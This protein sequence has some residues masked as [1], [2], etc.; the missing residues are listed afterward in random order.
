MNNNKKSVRYYFHCSLKDHLNVYPH[1]QPLLPS[2]NDRKKALAYG[3]FLFKAA[4]AKQ[5]VNQSPVKDMASRYKTAHWY[6]IEETTIETIIRKK[7]TSTSR[8]H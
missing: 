5:F 1:G 2:I 4:I 8:S 3:Q 6:I 7:F